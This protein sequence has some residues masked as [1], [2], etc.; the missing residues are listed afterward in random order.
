MNC[1]QGDVAIIVSASQGRAE[2]IGKI[3]TCIRFVGIGRYAATSR[4]NDF[5]ATDLPQPFGVNVHVSDSILRP[6]RDSD[7]QDE[8]LRITG[9]P[10]T[11]EKEKVYILK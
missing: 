1:K 4:F 10:K 7:K 5:W 8:M 9:L 6:L 11:K 3:L 2:Y